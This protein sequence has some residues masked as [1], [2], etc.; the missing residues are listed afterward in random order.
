MKNTGMLRKLDDMGRIVIPKEIRKTLHLH[1]SDTIEFSVE[2]NKLIMTRYSDLVAIR[3]ITEETVK[4]IEKIYHQSTVIICDTVKVIAVGQTA[5]AFKNQFLRND[6]LKILHKSQN[7]TRERV[8]VVN[9]ISKPSNYIIPIKS[10]GDVVGAIIFLEQKE[11]YRPEHIKGA[12]IA[13]AL[14][15]KML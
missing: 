4:T 9:G 12:E 5:Q 3:K 13:S 7:T 11:I 1:I 6:F 8:P 14:I 10:N 2:D 15:E